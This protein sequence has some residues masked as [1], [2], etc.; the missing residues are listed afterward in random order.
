MVT[1]I[2]LDTFE[3]IG[4]EESSNT[5]PTMNVSSKNFLKMNLLKGD[6]LA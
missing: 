2:G 5:H 6:L 3:K 1:I 4:V